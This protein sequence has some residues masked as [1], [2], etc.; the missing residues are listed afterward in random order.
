M[1]RQARQR[2][3]ERE[4]QRGPGRRSE[5]EEGGIHARDIQHHDRLPRRPALTYRVLHMG[6]LRQ[7][8]QVLFLDGDPDRIL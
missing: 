8:Q 2:G 4:S 3:P 6:V 1:A 5:E 7:E